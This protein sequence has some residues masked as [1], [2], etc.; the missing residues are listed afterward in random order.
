MCSIN[1]FQGMVFYGPIATI[2]RENHG[3]NLSEILFLESVLICITLIF[4]IPFGIYESFGTL[5]FL[6]A[7]IG[8][9]ILIKYS[10][11]VTVITTIIAYGISFII[12][13]SIVVQISIAM[14]MPVAISME[15][16]SIDEKNNNRAEILSIYG[17]IG[18]GGGVIVNFILGVASRGSLTKGFEI[19]FI[20]LVLH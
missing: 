2:Y 17:T 13:F 14:I 7:S 1:L 11:K 10:M 6:I 16:K 20:I 18:S 12:I 4:E 3:I 19:C 15:N 9:S 8:S 5:G